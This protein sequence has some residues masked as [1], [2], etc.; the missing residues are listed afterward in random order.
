LDRKVS[1]AIARRDI[2]RD[3]WELYELLTKGGLNL[4][5]SLDDYVLRFSVQE[6]DVYHVLRALAVFR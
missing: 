6:G 3:F 1:R 4:S 5:R 2:R